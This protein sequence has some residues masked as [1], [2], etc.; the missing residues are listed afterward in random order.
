MLDKLSRFRKF[1]S[2]IYGNDPNFKDNKTCLLPLICKKGAAFYRNST[3]EM[4][5]V[6]DKGETLCQCVWIVH[7]N[8][9]GV[10]NLAFFEAQEH[11]EEAVG[12]LLTYGEN[13]AKRLSCNRIIAGM[14]GHLN[15]SLGFSVGKQKAPSFGG[16]YNSDYYHDYFKGFTRHELVSF[17]SDFSYTY[18]RVKKDRE[19]FGSRFSEFSVEPGAIN[20]DNLMRY[21]R[22][23][24]QI[25]GN[26]LTYFKREYEEDQE[27]FDTMKILLKPENLL[28][29][30]HRNQDVG[31]IFWYVD[32]N[33]FVRPGKGFDGISYMR[34]LLNPRPK[35]V[36]LLEMG[37]IPEYQK[38]GAVMLAFY[39]A[40]SF[41]HKHFPTVDT[42]ISSWIWSKNWD[43]RNFT[44][45]Y[46]E[47]EYQTFAVYEKEL[48]SGG[49]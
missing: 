3:Q 19:R 44:K 30:R 31:Y 46:T 23:S 40:A 45:R 5:A 9:P 20:Q 47:R 8:N 18:G 11:C 42:V 25:F 49:D 2:R 17:I 10:L 14:D 16:S 34:Y 39:E 4:T 13:L 21:T 22:L 26:H 24:N 41:I 15:Y 6:V 37:L 38:S 7:K 43:S 12:L 36:K 28:F 27:L 32:Y 48:L 1:Y 33:Q 35:K 29:I